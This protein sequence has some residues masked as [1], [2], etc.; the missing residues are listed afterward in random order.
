M[1]LYGIT[2][3]D[4]KIAIEQ[5]EERLGPDG[6]ITIIHSGNPRFRLPLKVVALRRGRDLLVVTAYPLKK[7]REEI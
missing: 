1:R 6:R 2:E 3:E 7:T 4:V 5:G